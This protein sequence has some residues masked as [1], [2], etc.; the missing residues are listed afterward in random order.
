MAPTVFST[1]RDSPGQG[2]L[3]GPHFI[4][5]D[6]SQIGGDPGPDASNT[7]SP[8]TS[9]SL[10]ILDLAPSRMNLAFATTHSLEGPDAGFRFVLWR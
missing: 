8:G 6:E 1:G 4:D 5:L 3:V 10:G 2:G 7:M 9:S